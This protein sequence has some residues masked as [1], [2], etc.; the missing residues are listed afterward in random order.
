MEVGGEAPGGGLGCR[1]VRSVGDA[2][3]SV[4]SQRESFQERYVEAFWPLAALPLVLGG[5]AV[6]VALQP[7]VVA[8]GA[9]VVLA[10]DVALGE[11]IILARASGQVVRR[12]RQS[13]AVV[14]ATP[15]W[16]RGTRNL[17]RHGRR[18]VM[19]GPRHSRGHVA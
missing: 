8:V 4:P 11:V 2:R 5:V 3:R 6:A 7:S 17:R 10:I 14:S 9:L 15:N 18:G 12:A 1:W 16:V 13:L 19:E